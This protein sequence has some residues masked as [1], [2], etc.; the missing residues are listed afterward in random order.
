MIATI[1]QINKTTTGYDVIVELDSGRTKLF[2]FGEDVVVADIKQAI[3]IF[4]QTKKDQEGQ[5]P[6]LRAALIGDVIEV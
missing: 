2:D 3:R 6:K 4:L 1:K 5:L